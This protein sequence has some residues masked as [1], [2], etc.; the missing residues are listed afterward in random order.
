[1]IH[2]LL[3][4]EYL[5]SWMPLPE[6]SYAVIF[7]NV[8]KFSNSE[9]E[10]QRVRVKVKMKS[11]RESVLWLVRYLFSQYAVAS[12]A[13]GFNLTEFSLPRK[14]IDQKSSIH[15]RYMRKEKTHKRHLIKVYIFGYKCSFTHTLKHM[16]LLC[17][18]SLLC[19]RTKFPVLEKYI[20]Q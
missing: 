19:S 5:C 8:I 11:G 1:M 16:R 14:F 2:V 15:N 10:T 12:K 17:V 3:M 6:L 18:F 13:T 4:R 20:Y 7:A 9:C